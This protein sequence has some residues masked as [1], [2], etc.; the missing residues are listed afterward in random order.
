MLYFIK[1]GCPV[2]HRAAPFYEKIVDA[3]GEKANFVGV[4]NGDEAEA[5]K[6]LKEYKSDMVILPDPDKKLIKGY[7]VDFSPWAVSVESGKITNIWAGGSPKNLSEVNA[8]VA[9][10]AGA[11]AAK[12]SF[13]GAPAGGG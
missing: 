1:I 7:G 8:M 6:W 10:G 12:L 3:Y 13:E 2:N 9:K 4:I 11:S 5:K